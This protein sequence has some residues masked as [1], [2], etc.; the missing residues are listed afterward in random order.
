MVTIGIVGQSTLAATTVSVTYQVVNLEISDEMNISTVYDLSEGSK[1]LAVPFSVS[2]Y[3]TK[4]V[5]WYLDGEKLPFVKAED[6]IVDVSTS[7]SLFL[8]SSRVDILFSLE[9]M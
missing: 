5:E 8:I 1:T 6:E 4:T 7:I 9:R 3:G 2:G